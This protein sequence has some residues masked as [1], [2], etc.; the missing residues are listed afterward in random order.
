MFT[1]L[2]VRD[3]LAWLILGAAMIL[4]T[5]S[6]SYAQDLRIQKKDNGEVL[7]KYSDGK[8]KIS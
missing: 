8:K 5:I 3:I 7:L 6:V 1:K 2:N 4:L